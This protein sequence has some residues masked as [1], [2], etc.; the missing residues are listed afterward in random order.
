MYLGRQILFL[1]QTEYY[2]ILTMADEDFRVYIY[3]M[4]LLE[5][6]QKLCWLQVENLEILNAWYHI[7]IA[8]RYNS[9]SNSIR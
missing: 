2:F 4:V 7:V 3:K 1:I 5:Q 9:S 6:Q 8:S